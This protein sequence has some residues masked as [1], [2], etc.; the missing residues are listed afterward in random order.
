LERSG[1]K[2]KRSRE[3]AYLNGSALKLRNL[4][5]EITQTAGPPERGQDAR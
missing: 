3:R 1:K 2:S 4:R 5:V